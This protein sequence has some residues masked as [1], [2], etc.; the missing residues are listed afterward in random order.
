MEPE[1]DDTDVAAVAQ[2]IGSMGESKHCVKIAMLSVYGTAA[3]VYGTATS[4]LR[5][6]QTG[7]STQ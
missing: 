3:N 4:R 2:S 7:P 6:V 1:K 5:R